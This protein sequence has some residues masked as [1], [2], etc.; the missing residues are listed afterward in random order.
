VRS[1]SSATLDVPRHAG[2]FFGFTASSIPSEPAHAAAT[3][4]N[5]LRL[6]VE[7]GMLGAR[8]RE[9]S[10]RGSLPLTRRGRDQ[11]DFASRSMRFGYRRLAGGIAAPVRLRHVCG[12]LLG[13]SRFCERAIAALQVPDV[14]FGEAVPKASRVGVRPQVS[15]VRRSLCLFRGARRRS[16]ERSRDR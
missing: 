10:R 9:G 12:S 4:A 15:C 14:S 16:H 5:R 3:L 8:P 7:H 11:Y 1:T 2:A 13:A 6:L